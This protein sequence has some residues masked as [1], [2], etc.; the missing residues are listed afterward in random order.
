VRRRRA[1]DV[2]RVRVPDQQAPLFHVPGPGGGWFASLLYDFGTSVCDWWRSGHCPASPTPRSG[3]GYLRCGCEGGSEAENC[4]RFFTIP[5]SVESW[6]HASLTTK[7]A[8]LPTPD[9]TCGRPEPRHDRVHR[10]T[11]NALACRVHAER[12]RLRQV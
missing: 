1:R 7:K 9:H 2:V 11:A 6:K 12:R 4:R 10:R 5:S 8:A 3:S